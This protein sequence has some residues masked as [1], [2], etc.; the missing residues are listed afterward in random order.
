MAD[1]DEVEAWRQRRIGALPPDPKADERAAAI[2]DQ[3]WD[4]IERKRRGA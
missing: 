4:E 2:N 3:L 1:F